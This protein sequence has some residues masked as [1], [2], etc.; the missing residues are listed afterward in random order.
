MG[1]PFVLVRMREPQGHSPNPTCLIFDL[2]A[3]PPI[4]TPTAFRVTKLGWA[5]PPL[6]CS[7]QGA[8]AEAALQ[9]VAV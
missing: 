7:A 3:L 5:A 8:E 9:V 4:A 6:G 1:T 2:G